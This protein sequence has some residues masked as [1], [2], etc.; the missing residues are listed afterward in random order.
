MGKV[1]ILKFELK[2]SEDLSGEAL[3]ILEDQIA[4]WLR[5]KDFHGSVKSIDTESIVQI[6][7]SGRAF[8]MRFEDLLGVE[9]RYPASFWEARNKMPS[10]EK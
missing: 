1:E 10:G 2:L 9:V 3:E 6:E 7:D 5:L 8:Q 4:E